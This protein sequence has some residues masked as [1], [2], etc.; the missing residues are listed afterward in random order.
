[1]GETEKTK[2]KEVRSQLWIGREK[3]DKWI[4]RAIHGLDRGKTD[5]YTDRKKN[6]QMYGQS[7]G[8]HRQ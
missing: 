8:C 3:M 6:K 5:R 2:Q 1:M 7:H 4:F